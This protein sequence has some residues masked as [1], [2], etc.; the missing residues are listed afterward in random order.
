MAPNKE[1]KYDD[2]VWHADHKSNYR[3]LPLV[4]VEAWL[5]LDEVQVGW[6]LL[7]FENQNRLDQAGETTG[8]LRV[9]NVGLN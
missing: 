6:D 2:D 1:G 4:Q 3:N 8:R 9:A 5:R 7:V